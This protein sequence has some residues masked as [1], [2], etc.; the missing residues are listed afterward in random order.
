MQ[1]VD[2]NGIILA[3]NPSHL[4]GPGGGI[5]TQDD[6]RGK[7]ILTRPSIL[8][9]GLSDDYRRVLD[10]IPFTKNEVQFPAL[11]GGGSGYSNVRGVLFR[12]NFAAEVPPSGLHER[13][14]RLPRKENYIAR[15]R[16]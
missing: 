5:L 11:S 15:K 7:D 2:R 8:A 13:C 9:S 12:V 14:R 4:V 1:V 3:V 6:Y 16:T 10:G